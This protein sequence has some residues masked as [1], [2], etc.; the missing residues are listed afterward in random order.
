MSK[1]KEL[2]GL[3]PGKNSCYA[4]SAQA[5]HLWYGDEVMMACQEAGAHLYVAHDVQCSSIVALG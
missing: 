4:E 2:G 1:R 5:V 3:Q